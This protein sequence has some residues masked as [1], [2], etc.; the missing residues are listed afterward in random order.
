MR[1]LS[2]LFFVLVCVAGTGYGDYNIGSS[3]IDGGGGVSTGGTYIVR[4][5][6]A[7]PEAA[8]SSADDYEL[9]GGFWPGEPSC[10]VDL[11][12]FSIIAQYWMTIG[13]GLRADLYKDEHNIVDELDLAEF[14]DKWLYYCP[15]DW[16]LK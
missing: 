5:T 13:I 1:N 15:Y 8:V 7:Q 11:K 9:L 16:P 4:G 10:I 6:I 14:I 12:Q 3:T 2:F